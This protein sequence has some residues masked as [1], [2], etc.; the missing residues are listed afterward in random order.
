MGSHPDRL[1]TAATRHQVMAPMALRLAMEL[2]DTGHLPVTGL[3]LATGLRRMAT[4]HQAMARQVT[5]LRQATAHPRVQATAHQGV[6]VASLAVRM[7][8]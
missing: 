4:A 8:R 2:Q 6:P 3:H 7:E 5:T 1:L